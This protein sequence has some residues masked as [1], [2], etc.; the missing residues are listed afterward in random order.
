MYQ[1]SFHRFITAVH[2]EL[3]EFSYKGV[4]VVTFPVLDKS[5]YELSLCHDHHI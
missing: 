3:T 1:E 4:R 2:S 5:K